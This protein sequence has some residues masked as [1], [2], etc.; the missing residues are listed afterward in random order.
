MERKVEQ[1]VSMEFRI[2]DRDDPT[3]ARQRPSVELNIDCK[4]ARVNALSRLP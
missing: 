3:R 4:P 1:S 2:K